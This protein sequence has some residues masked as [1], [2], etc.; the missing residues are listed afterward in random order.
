MA[1]D[2]HDV[3]LKLDAIWFHWGSCNWTWPLR[4]LASWAF[5]W[6]H[7]PGP[8]SQLE[9]LMRDTCACSD[10]FGFNC[11]SE[12][13]AVRMMQGLV[14]THW[15]TGRTKTGLLKIFE[16][17]QHR[18]QTAWKKSVLKIWRMHDFYC[19]P[20]LQGPSIEDFIIIKAISRGAFGWVLK[21]S[22]L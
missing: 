20:F 10:M 17:A 12:S 2:F 13:V 6:P 8:T 4:A 16:T 15:I 3:T 22:V 7:P 14:R 5:G 9:S 11:L 18:H 21:V 1:L 19:F